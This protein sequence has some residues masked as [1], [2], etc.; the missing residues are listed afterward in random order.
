MRSHI[1]LNSNV[2]ASKQLIDTKV[3]SS[4]KLP[5]PT[6]LPTLN[7]CPVKHWI[8]RQGQWLSF[9]SRLSDLL[10]LFLGDLFICSLLFLGKRLLS[11]YCKCSM[12]RERR[13]TKP[14]R[15]TGK[16]TVAA[17]VCLTGNTTTCFWKRKYTIACSFGFTQDEDFNYLRIVYNIEIVKSCQQVLAPSTGEVSQAVA[18]M[19][20]RASCL[21]NTRG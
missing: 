6:P 5:L 18:G 1:S 11:S 20:I 12:F 15:L 3:C 14:A 16:F 8:V 2:F 10:L 7:N 17:R 21:A 4:S 9:F 19:V 13:K